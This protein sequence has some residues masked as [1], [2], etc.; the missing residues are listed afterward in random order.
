M[1]WEVECADFELRVREITIELEGRQIPVMTLGEGSYLVHGCFAMGSMEG[2]V[3]VGRYCSLADGVTFM[4]GTD[5]NMQHTATY[6][7]RD[8]ENIEKSGMMHHGYETNHC[9]IILGNDVW[10][11]RGVTIQG[12]VHVGNGAVVGA[13]AVVLE[14]VPPYAVAVGNPAKVVKYRFSQEVIDKLQD[15]KWWNWSEQKIK[16]NLELMKYPELFVTHY[17]GGESSGGKG[18]DVAEQLKLLRDKGYKLYAFLADFKSARPVWERV[19]MQ[20]MQMFEP[21]DHTILLFAVMGQEPLGKVEVMMEKYGKDSSH[22]VLLGDV[23]T[24]LPEF[25]RNVHAFVTTR[26]SVSSWC[27][28]FAAGFGVEVL[29]GLDY[30]IFQAG[31]QGSYFPSIWKSQDTILERKRVLVEHYFQQRKESIRNFWI[32]KEYEKTLEGIASLAYQLYEYNQSYTDSFLEDCLQTVREAISNSLPKHYEKRRD[33]V[34][35][36]DGFGF[37]NRGLARTYLQ[38]LCELGY[39][40]IYVTVPRAKG[41]IPVLEKI[42]LSYQSEI[43]YLPQSGFIKQYR[44]LCYRIA[45]ACPKHAFLYTTPHDVAGIMAFEHFEGIPIRYQVNLTD[46]AFWLG[47]RAFDYCLEFRNYGLSI[48]ALYRGIPKEKLWLL[49]Y[50]PL[51][52]KEV[53]FQGFPF[54]KQEGDFIIFSGGWLYKTIDSDGT[55]YRIVDECLKHHP[56]VKFWYAGVGD[57]TYLKNLVEKYPGRV[58]HTGERRDLFAIMQHIDMYLNT[59]PMAGGL[60]MQIAAVAGR[61]PMTLR[62]AGRGGGILI[63][64]ERLG[65]EFFSAM[66]FQEAIFRFITNEDYRKNLERD[67]SKAVME[68]KDFNRRLRNIMESSSGDRGEIMTIEVE[69]MQREYLERFLAHVKV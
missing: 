56:W 43:Y 65:I 35:F 30:D 27:V 28:D 26:E 67:I 61:A 10:I 55:Y 25:V 23:S 34:L 46:H 59:Y 40:V 33:T 54:E 1:L 45:D 64:Q 17:A 52:D 5:C 50:Y 37:E 44:A 63:G 20:Y 8:T 68:P 32:R 12:G 57:D 51:I 66:D 9:Q 41:N 60:M 4:V 7:F 3:L 69:E 22:V 15:I 18:T 16:E 2:H 47:V 19:L 11:G 62:K 6:P 38:A 42:L 48:S 58:F 31:Y 14:D 29:S 53:E 21:K 39:R 49:P 36:Y 24:I 13:G